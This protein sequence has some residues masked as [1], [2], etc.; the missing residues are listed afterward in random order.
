M[1]LLSDIALR[2][3][4]LTIVVNLVLLLAGLF[5]LTRLSVREY[6]DIDAPVISVSTNY[7]GASA[8]VVE[9][10]ITRVLEDAL[11]GIPGIRRLS[12]TSREGSS[13]ISVEF[14]L[15][16][17]I[18]SAANDIRD[19]VSRAIRRLPEGIDAP[20]IAK[21]DA[22][23]NAMIWL[24]LTSD[25]RGNIALTE[26]AERFLL[27]RFAAVDGVARAF[28]GGGRRLAMRIHLDLDA[29]AARQLTVADVEGAIRAQNLSLP[30]GRIETG[31]REFTVKP[32]T[33]LKTPEQFADIIIARRND[34][35]IRLGEV[36]DIALAAD[37]EQ[38]ELRANGSPG[39]GIGII[40]QARAN[41]LQ[42]ARGVKEVLQRI[43]ADLPADMKLEISYDQSVFISRSM[44]EV[45]KALAI[46]MALVTGVIFLFLRRF[47]ATLIP[48]VAIPVSIVATLAVL[49]MLGYSVN[50]LTLLALVLAI[51]LVVDDAIVVLENNHRRLDQGETAID[52]AR[53]GTRQ[54][55]F[56]VIA[57][58]V[59]LAVT[60]VP[61]SFL[62]GNTG[63]LFSE[64]GV[65]IAAAVIISSFVALTLTPVMCARLLRPHR[66]AGKNS[67]NRPL[68]R[69][70]DLYQGILGSLCRI[71]LIVL[72]AVIVISLA[73]FIL[74]R[75]L[76][77]ELAPAED[78]G[79]FYISASAPEGSGF[80]Y[81]RRYALEIEN[82]LLPDLEN[83]PLQRIIT[84]IAPAFGRPGESNRAFFIVRLRPWEERNISLKAY[85]GALYPRLTAVPGLRAF[86]FP[87]A[88]LGQRSAG[89][90]VNISIGGSDYSRIADWVDRLVQA[91]EDSPLLINPA[92]GYRAGRPELKVAIDRDRAA[93]LG[94]SI[95]DVGRTLET[96]LGGRRIG[97]FEQG[98]E[99]RDIML[100]A[101][102]QDRSDPADMYNIRGRSR[103]SGQLIP[104]SNL[105]RIE[106]TVGSGRLAHVDKLRTIAFTA[107]P[108]EGVS[109]SQAL[110]FVE[111]TARAQL[112]EEARL[113]LSGQSR[114]FRDSSQ[115]L[116]LTFGFALLLVYLALAA[117]FESFLHP[118]SILIAVPLAITGALA[119]LKITGL[120]LNIYSQIGLIMLIGLTAKNAILIVE[121]A[122]QLAM[123]GYGKT[124][125][126]T[127]AARI[128]LRPII[129]TT[130]STALG[131]L[132]LALASGA[133]AEARIALGTV[134]IGGIGFSTL[135]SLFVV[136]VIHVL[137]SGAAPSAAGADR[138]SRS[139][140]TK[141]QNATE[142]P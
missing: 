32:S 27:D 68:G 123:Q 127:L 24:G 100:R 81:T 132:P 82:L 102:P 14:N 77:G 34:Y 96:V 94:V 114:E 71:P 13:S 64:F 83:G 7:P 12:S 51:G 25:E 121:F 26:Y 142:T 6:P 136:P 108:A 134:L 119:T 49:L 135:L 139:K 23:A 125:A 18:E 2:R 105:I 93:T 5:A 129:M 56:A 63:R 124:E 79:V 48:V 29:L 65:S 53:N 112:P 128:R 115:A 85:I 84:I 140:T 72:A 116:F 90:A 45:F 60:F 43:R 16:R 92:S 99:D 57:T 86:A 66:N 75:Q 126:A 111:E 17:D 44:S 107:T 61:L 54:I 58:T 113:I 137:L 138:I 8:E 104:L 67:R 101:R 22:D 133:G 55:G 39:I 10:Q 4:V 120:S 42:V 118:V 73:A 117:Q 130:L 131:A 3:P 74:F 78:R 88:S 50:V 37:N 15:S 70:G 30:A 103:D 97:R 109:L 35:P 40:R 59:V 33:A 95:E 36:A 47:G 106:E 31:L 91:A 9:R 38:T 98:G 89:A 122:N 21:A 87:P 11:G 52:A 20:R 41:T 62:Q 69:F 28:V 141:E 1:F 46:A 76:P 80:A 19:A 110:A